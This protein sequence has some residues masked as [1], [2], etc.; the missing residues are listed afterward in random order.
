MSLKISLLFTTVIIIQPSGSMQNKEDG[1]EDLF[2]RGF[3]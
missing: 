1:G 3:R 2:E